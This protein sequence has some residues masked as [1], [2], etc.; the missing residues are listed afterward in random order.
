MAWNGFGVWALVAQTLTAAVFSAVFLNLITRWVP[1][2]CF[3]K[4]S[5]DYLFGFG[6]KLLISGLLDS[7]Y[8]NLYQI[9]IGK[10]FSAENVGQFTQANQISSIPAM[11]MTNIIQRV[12]Y[13]MFSHMQSDQHKMDEYYLLTMKVAALFIFR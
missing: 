1:V 8:N 10:R 12:T 2:F 3:S 13:P 9:I 5:F 4:K 11:T 6:G 7:A